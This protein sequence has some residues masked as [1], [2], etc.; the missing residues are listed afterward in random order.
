[1]ITRARTSR[2]GVGRGLAAASGARRPRRRSAARRAHDPRR[3]AVRV[4]RAQREEGV[5]EFN[6]EE[7]R[8]FTELARQVALACTTPSSTWRCAPPSRRCSTRTPSCRSPG[9]ASWR[10]PTPSVAR[11]SATCTTAPSSTWWRWRCSC[12]SSSGWG[13][14]SR[15]RRWPWWTSAQRG[16]GH[17]GGAAG[18]GPRHLPTAVD[19][20]GAGGGHACRRRAFGVA[21]DRRGVE[22]GRYAEDIEAAVYFCCLE[23]MQNAGKHAGEGRRSPSPARSTASC[24]SRSRRRRRLRRGRRPGRPRL[25]QHGRPPGRH[26]RLRAVTSSPGKGTCVSGRI[27]VQPLG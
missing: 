4:A 21:H 25:C 26:R 14:R 9:P 15:R 16:A 12:A 5:D 13:V 2:R 22:L 27:P 18:P 17:G 7:E 24:V 11:S 23:A 1:M 19:G 8:V 20:E 6:E 10:R 3:S